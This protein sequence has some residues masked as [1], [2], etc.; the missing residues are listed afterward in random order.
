M[1]NIEKLI[2]SNPMKYN[3]DTLLFLLSFT[4]CQREKNIERTF[5]VSAGAQ[6]GRETVGSGTTLPQYL[7][8]P[9]N[10]FPRK[11]IFT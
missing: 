7:P 5:F 6:K 1:K 3:A 10:E 8:N 4:K 11:S 2:V 9:K